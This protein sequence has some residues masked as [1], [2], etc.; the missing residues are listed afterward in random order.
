MLFEYIS[1]GELFSRLRKDGRFS[2]DVALFYACEILLSIQYL[3]QKDIV[4]RDLKPENLLIDKYGHIKIT[5]FGFAKR[6]EN[7][8]TYTLCGTPEYLAPEI[9]KGS[10]VGYGKSVDWWALGILIFEMLSGYPPFYDNE[11]IGIYKKI[12]AGIIEFPRFFDVR[13]K[14]LIRKLLNPEL[15]LRL[16]VNNN[17]ESIKQHKWFRGVDWDE[18]L[19]REIPAPWVPVLKSEED[20]S[21]FE[22]YPDSKEPAKELPRELDY[23]FDDF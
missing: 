2:N 1:G 13:S 5:D 7:N 10:K 9:I 23:L 15:S 22:K 21:W 3:H 12:I 19:R 11:P 8:R 16:G 4:Y 17:G 6:I 14:D 18:V 20:C